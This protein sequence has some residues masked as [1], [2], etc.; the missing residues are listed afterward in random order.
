M[1]DLTKN[2]T[3]RDE[4]RLVKILADITN[5]RV[6]LGLLCFSFLTLVVLY[7]VAAFTIP[8]TFVDL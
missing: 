7:L 8:H 3:G 5:K 4:K 2:Y 6:C 1:E